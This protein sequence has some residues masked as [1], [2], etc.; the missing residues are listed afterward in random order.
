MLMQSVSDELRVKSVFDN[1]TLI[2]GTALEGSLVDL[3]QPLL[4]RHFQK[5]RPERR[6]KGNDR[7]GIVNIFVDQFVVEPDAMPRCR[8]RRHQR[9]LGECVVDVIKDQ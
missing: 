3:R 6:G 4:S 5:T 7:A 9:W 1:A 2:F 8:R